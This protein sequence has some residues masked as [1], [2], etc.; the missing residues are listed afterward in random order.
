MNDDYLDNY[1]Q[2]KGITLELHLAHFRSALA[3]DEV[4]KLPSAVIATVLALDVLPPDWACAIALDRPKVTIT[5]K[6]IDAVCKDA[7]AA[8]LVADKCMG[9]DLITSDQHNQLISAVLA[10]ADAAYCF[11]LSVSVTDFVKSGQYPW[12]DMQPFVN[13]IAT[14][15]QH[16]LLSLQKF[17]LK[18]TPDQRQQFV[19][20]VATDPHYAQYALWEPKSLT[21]DQI[22]QL[23]AVINV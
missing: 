17:Y 19:N 16:S 18:L 3:S 15:A 7:T 23:K 13:I 10:D 2:E 11:L 1:L 5:Q 22:N 6:M 4:V 8:L 12:P 21:E 9:T 20:T 14:S